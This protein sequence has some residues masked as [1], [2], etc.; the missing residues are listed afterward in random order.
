MKLL[1][2]NCTI[3]SCG[4]AKD[5]KLLL[6]YFTIFSCGEA[7]DMKL[8]LRY[9]IFFHVEK[10]KIWH[11]CSGTVLYSSQILSPLL[12]DIVT[13]AWKCR[14]TELPAYVAWRAGIYADPKPQSTTSPNQG[15]R[16]RIQEA[17]FFQVH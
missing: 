9:C 16:I 1:L 15:L 17:I 12:G 10:P 5:M 2:R 6:R 3:F 14:G 11:C 7:K 4:E 13:L 8:L